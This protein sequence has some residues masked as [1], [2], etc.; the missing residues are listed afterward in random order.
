MKNLALCAG[1]FFS[2]SA[3][4]AGGPTNVGGISI[5][6]SKTEYLSAIGIT[7]IDCN[8]FKDGDGKAKRSELK[9][10]TPE[11]KTL[12]WGFALT[13]TGSTENILVGGISYDV[14]EANYE[15]SKVVDS[16]GHSSKAIFL[17]DRLISIEI[18]SPKVSLETLTNK[19]GPPKLAEITKIEICQNR[20]GSEFK[21]KVGNIDA[22]W[23]N[24]D[25]TAILRMK[26][27]PPSKTCSDGFNMKYYIIEE[28]KQLEPI[29]AAINNF[30][31]EIAK[32]TAKDSPF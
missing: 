17:K 10:L 26:L 24:G 32:T 19:Y 21:N 30:R 13:K 25:V 28:R 4:A 9:S 11:K 8:T 2:F 31:K 5:G 29:E 3:F 22:V 12:C 16:I 7:P 1:I 6:M 27:N 14:V 20:M 18:Y 23:T 15:S